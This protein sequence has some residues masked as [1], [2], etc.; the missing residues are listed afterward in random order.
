MT[1]GT[2]QDIIE[3]VREVSASGNSLQVTDEKIIKYINSYYLYDL[4]NDLRNIKL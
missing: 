2:L 3:K 1:I 4:P